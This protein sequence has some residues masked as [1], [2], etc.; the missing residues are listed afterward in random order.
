MGVLPKIQDTLFFWRLSVVL[1]GASLDHA[2][3][4]LERVKQWLDLSSTA[5]SLPPFR[6]IHK[7][8]G[9]PNMFLLVK[10]TSTICGISDLSQLK[11]W[12]ISD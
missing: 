11:K 7:L 1:E 4:I 5:A 9:N 3:I 2:D 6:A 10:S 8:N 12:T